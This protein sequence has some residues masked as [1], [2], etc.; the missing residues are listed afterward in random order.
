MLQKTATTAP[1]KSLPPIAIDDV[2]SQL[3]RR[4]SIDLVDRVRSGRAQRS[5]WSRQRTSTVAAL[6]HCRLL[7]AELHTGLQLRESLHRLLREF[8]CGWIA[9]DGIQRGQGRREVR[10]MGAEADE[11]EPAGENSVGRRC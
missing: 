9:A 4:Q 2:R 8:A 7:N 5:I 10:R 6:G 11:V 1:A 3:G